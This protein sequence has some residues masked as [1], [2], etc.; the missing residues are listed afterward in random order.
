M[1]LFA[2]GRDFGLLLWAF[3]FGFGEM[4][5]EFNDETALSTSTAS[6]IQV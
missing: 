5:A 4:L 3:D 6:T 2:V 1:E